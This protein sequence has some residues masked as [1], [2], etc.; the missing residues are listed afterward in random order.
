[1]G[2]N[3]YGISGHLPIFAFLKHLM[4]LLRCNSFRASFLYLIKDTDSMYRD[5]QLRYF[6]R[7]KTLLN[8]AFNVKRARGQNIYNFYEIQC[9]FAF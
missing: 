8:N 7:V 1:M 2:R 4:L 5:M 6:F 3:E 9:E